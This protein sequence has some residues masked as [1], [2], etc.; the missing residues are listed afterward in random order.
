MKK[1]HTTLDDN[2]KVETKK[3]E[4]PITISAP[5]ARKKKFQS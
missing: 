3:K 5:A 1:S 2:D 4:V